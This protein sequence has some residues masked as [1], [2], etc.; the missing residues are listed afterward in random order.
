M[1]LHFALPPPLSNP[2]LPIYFLVFHLS[3]RFVPFRQSLSTST[4][5]RMAGV[6]TIVCNYE[7]KTHKVLFYP[8]G[9][10]SSYD[11]YVT[12]ISQLKNALQAEFGSSGNLAYITN[13]GTRKDITGDFELDAAV[14]NL[15]N[16]TVLAI[17]LVGGCKKGKGGKAKKGNKG[18]QAQSDSEE[19][20]KSQDSSSDTSPKKKKRG[21]AGNNESQ[22][23]CHHCDKKNWSGNRYQYYT[24]Y[25]YS[26]CNSCYEKLDKETKKTWEL[27][28]GQGKGKGKGKNKNK[29]E[30]T[31]SDSDT[32]THDPS[33]GKKKKNKNKKKG[34]SSSD[35]KTD[36]IMERFVYQQAECYHCNASNWWGV[37]YEYCTNYWYSLCGSC[38]NALDGSDKKTWELSDLPWADVVPDASLE[39]EYGVPIR[40]EVR[41]LQ[42]ILTVLGEMKLEETSEF[43]GSYQYYTEKAV[44]S[45]R[46]KH[47]VKGGNTKCY[48]ENTR[49]KLKEVVKKARKDG[50]KSL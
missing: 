40:D 7:G 38:Y 48:D 13:T 27:V 33:A 1:H 8:A 37:R 46:K 18:K 17:T 23:K 36:K 21:G 39:R 44:Q 6:Y 41:Q 25:G 50:N 22:A 2:S 12:S 24:H 11:G 35:K 16:G 31:Y 10:G 45:F 42:Y 30:D 19:D 47:N 32:D 26:L 34:G 43:T 29:E 14:E 20:S 4:S 15:S 5:R 9:Y 28:S 49:K 3:T